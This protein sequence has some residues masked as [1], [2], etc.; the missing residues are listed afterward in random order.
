MPL[1]EVLGYS[2][3]R[4]EVTTRLF[5]L[6]LVKVNKYIVLRSFTFAANTLLI[7]KYSKVPLDGGKGQ[8][9]FVQCY[10]GID[11]VG[12][13]RNFEETIRGRE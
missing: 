11:R 6:M 13:R 8:V 3:E 10:I 2:A 7:I 12:L 9:R 4:L 1:V 5:V